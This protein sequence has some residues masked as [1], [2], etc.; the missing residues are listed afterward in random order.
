MDLECATTPAALVNRRERLDSG[1]AVSSESQILG[2]PDS[3][4]SCH[5]LGQFSAIKWP[6]KGSRIWRTFDHFRGLGQS[7]LL[8]EAKVCPLWCHS[9]RITLSATCRKGKAFQSLFVSLNQ[10]VTEK[11]KHFIFCQDKVAQPRKAKHAGESSQK[12]RYRVTFSSLF[13][14]RKQKISIQKL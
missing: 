9:C 6:K 13:T 1:P 8:D 12:G 2:S 10:M 7:G 11:Q 4:P 14:T 5:I 3:C